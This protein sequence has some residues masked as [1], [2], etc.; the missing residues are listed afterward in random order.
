MRNYLI[1]DYVGTSPDIVWKSVK[2]DI[3]SLKDALE[4]IVAL[5]NSA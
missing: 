2:D 1:H 3:P 4:N 5:G